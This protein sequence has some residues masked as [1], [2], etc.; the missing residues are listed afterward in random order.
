M[1]INMAGLDN[2]NKGF[3]TSSWFMVFFAITSSVSWDWIMSID[4]LGSVHYLDGIFFLSGAVIGFVTILL[5]T[6]YLK[7]LNI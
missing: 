6:L 7:R 1:K 2:Y 4:T 3:R 5:I